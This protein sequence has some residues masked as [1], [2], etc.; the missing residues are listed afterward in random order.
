MDLDL[1]L[2]IEALFELAPDFLELL[3]LV[4]AADLRV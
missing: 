2:T 3:F 4:L 1:L